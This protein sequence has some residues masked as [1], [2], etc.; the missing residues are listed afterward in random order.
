MSH[1][2]AFV[3]LN[4]MDDRPT[5]SPP[6]LTAPPSWR[7]IDIIS[8]LHLQAGHPRT[9]EAFSQYLSTTPA[10]A[11]FI[12]GDLFEAW[13]GDDMREL[14]FE[15]E[16]TRVLAQAGRRLRLHLMVGN[17]DFLLGQAMA[18][19]CHAQLLDDPLVL[20]AFGQRH[21]L[22]HGDAWCLDDTAYLAFRAQV[23]QPAW[24]AAFR[25]APMAARLQTARELREG[26]EAR[27]QMLPADHDWADVD[28]AFAGRQM[29]AAD[30]SVLIHGHTHHPVSQ[31]FGADGFIRHVLSDWE[32]EAEPPRAEV[33]RLSAAGIERLTPARASLPPAPPS[34]M[35]HAPK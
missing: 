25:A 12:L 32:L 9:F 1:R 22:T 19:A 8:D 20:S 18:Q 34:A 6:E 17:R 7:C 31:A 16:C 11:V 21:L 4:P 35:P 28:E 30:T 23:R 14:P 29:L 15:A 27:K 2:P 13:V 10:D 3:A 26:S 24:Q 33:L 5:A